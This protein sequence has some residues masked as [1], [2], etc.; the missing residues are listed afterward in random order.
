M[1]LKLLII[2]LIFISN[3]SVAQIHSNFKIQELNLTDTSIE[4]Y[5]ILINQ[6][7]D[8]QIIAIGEASHGTQEFY[9][10]K[11]S[12]V[13]HLIQ[14]ERFGTLAFEMD[15]KIAEQINN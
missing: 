9:I 11:S 2:T 7:K 14:Q 13:R 6:L 1:Y 4:E 12:I 10:T 5:S 3:T 15:E 8:K